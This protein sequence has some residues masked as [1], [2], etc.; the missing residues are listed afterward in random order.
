V[1]PAPVVTEEDVVTLAPFDVSTSQD[2]GYRANSTLAGSRLNSELRDTAASISVMTAEFLADLGAVD[3]ASALEYGNNVQQNRSDEAGAGNTGNGVVEFYA[4]YRIRGIKANTA[5]NFYTWT[6]PSDTYN[7]ERIDESRGPNSILFGIGSAGGIIN[8][9]TKVALTNA[10]RTQLSVI[11]S[12][13]D[14][15]RSTLDHNQVLIPRKLAVRFN[16]V[17]EDS[18]SFRRFAGNKKALGHLA[19]TWRINSKS[20]LKV[21]AELGSIR[22][23]VTR[24]WGLLD[25]IRTWEANGRTI[26]QTQ[27]NTNANAGITRNA[28]NVARVTLVEQAG[29]LQDR[30]GYNFTS[31]PVAQGQDGVM[32][33]F[34]P[35]INTQGPNSRTD[36]EFRSLTANFEHQFGDK[37]FLQVGYNHQHYEF[38]GYDPNNGGTNQLRADPNSRLGN[39]GP[40]NPFAGQYYLETIWNRRLRDE[41]FDT[42]RATLS[43]E[44]DFGA[45]GRHRLAGLLEYQ[46]STFAS[47]SQR[48]IWVGAPFNATPENAANFVY[49]FN[50][51][52]LKD[53]STV[54]TSLLGGRNLI[55]NLPF[56]SGTL[57]S[58]WIQLNSNIEDDDTQMKTFMIGTQSFFLK[59]R[60]VVTGGFRRDAVDIKDR[61]TTRDPVTQHWIVD[62]NNVN[63][64]ATSANTRTY[65][66]VGHLGR[67]VSLLYNNSSSFNLA[68]AAHRILPNSERAPN[69]PGEGEDYGIMFNLLDNKFSVRIT[70]FSSASRGETFFEGAEAATTQRNVRILEALRGAGAIS[71][72][73]VLARTINVNTARADRE[74]EGY[75]VSLVAN[76]TR[77]WTLSVNYSYTNAISNNSVPE[78]VEWANESIAYWERFDTNLVTSGS[79]TIATEIFNLRDY[80]R[81]R[82]GPDGRALE[83]NRQEKYNFFTRYSFDGALKGV[84]VGG[85]Y[86]Y[87]GKMMIG[88]DNN[89]ELQFGNAIESGDFLLGYNFRSKAKHTYSLQLNVQNLFDDTDPIITRVFPDNS[90]PLRALFQ[91][92][93]TFRLTASV[94]F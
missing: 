59:N 44:F 47:R 90:R 69:W 39:N 89:N 25:H 84:F 55:N 32:L 54:R 53:P 20:A 74:T 26:Y 80:I 76:P 64:I 22:S 70:R 31:V 77:N 4:N 52:D 37:T 7:V 65:G 94:K 66:A 17:Y 21:D 93:R 23:V 72:A 91:D 16:A 9:S 15:L 86:R 42:L 63:K 78:V 56:G 82:T 2:V 43:T 85:G 62:Y 5:R 18:G 8:A 12:S 61:G 19:A 33:G 3:V 41:T 51:I 87:Q 11:A 75:E 14:S 60:L 92:G 79:T 10:N 71:Q 6:L 46:D 27:I 49:H 83:G 1:A 35:S 29:G 30:R 57:S 45:A 36:T 50:Y 68:N 81:Q 24:P 13:H 88:I 28:T 58:D 67:G 48:E 40:A 38:V 73:D 34:D